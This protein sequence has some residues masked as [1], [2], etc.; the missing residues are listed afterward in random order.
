MVEL[1]I[2]FDGP[3]KTD[4]EAR[5]ASE[6]AKRIA[7]AADKAVIRERAEFDRALDEVRE[8]ERRRFRRM[9]E[10]ERAAID[11]IREDAKRARKAP[12]LPTVDEVLQRLW[13]NAGDLVEPFPPPPAGANWRLIR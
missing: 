12:V 7:E 10:A 1:T 13:T 8:E 5:Q 2:K 9:V 11:G 3:I 4:D 6:I